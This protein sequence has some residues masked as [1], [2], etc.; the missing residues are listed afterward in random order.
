[1]TSGQPNDYLWEE[2]RK[3]RETDDKSY[4]QGSRTC[5]LIRN[6]H[7]GRHFGRHSESE[8]DNQKYGLV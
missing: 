4:L 2:W 5:W 6:E 8:Q 1:M 3:V 7:R